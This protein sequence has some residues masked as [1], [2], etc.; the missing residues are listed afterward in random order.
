M[1][2]L[3]YLDGTVLDDLRHAGAQQIVEMHDADRPV[4][5]H[6]DE[7]GDLRGVEQLQRLAGQLIGPHGFRR[8]RHHLVDRCLQQIVTHVAAQIAVGDDAGKFPVGID[9]RHAAEAL[10][11]HFD[12]R[13][14]HRCAAGD[15]RAR[16]RP[17]A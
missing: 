8:Y 11:R 4:F 6:D 12:D 17:D 2:N 13:L 7:R 10:G 15:Q 3:S 9:D 16:R 14:R 5:F 1:V